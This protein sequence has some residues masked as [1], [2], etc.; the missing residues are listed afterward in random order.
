MA[1]RPKKPS[2]SSSEHDEGQSAKEDEDVG[3]EGSPRGNTPLRSPN[4]TKQHN[5]KVPTPPPSPPMTTVPVSVAQSPPPPTTQNTTA[6]PPSPPASTIP[7]STTPF[8][9]PI[10]SQATTTTTPI[11]TTANEPPVN[12]NAF[13]DNAFEQYTEAIDKSTK[14]VD[15]STFACNKATTDVAELINNIQIFLDSLKGHV[16]D[17]AAKVNASVDSLSKSLQEEKLNS[18]GSIG[19]RGSGNNFAEKT[20]HAVFQSCA[21]DV[22]NMLN[23]VLQAHDSI[24]T[25]TIWNHLT[26]KLLPATE[27]LREMKG[28]TKPLVT[29]QQG[30]EGTKRT[31]TDKPKVI[32]K[33][34]PKVNVAS[35]SG[36]QEKIKGLVEEDDDSDNEENIVD[37]LK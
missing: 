8:P 2:S 31:T 33:T 36:D 22:L 13:L 28:V 5:D 4:P 10:I 20:E 3:H 1:R 19:S 9:P 7:F 23:N 27:R 6:V 32:V 34:E 25:L 29:L 26:T 12:V 16:D 35:G 11:S 24:L 21:G 17:N 37:P 15:A 14:T 18:K 30:G